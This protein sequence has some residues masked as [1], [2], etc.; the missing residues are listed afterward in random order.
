MSW[1]NL[2]MFSFGDKSVQEI[3]VQAINLFSASVCCI[4]CFLCLSECR[5]AGH[6]N[7]I[8]VEHHHLHIRQHPNCAF[9]PLGISAQTHICLSWDE[10][11]ECVRVWKSFTC[12]RLVF[13]IS[14]CA[15]TCWVYLCMK[16]QCVHVHTAARVT[17]WAKWSFWRFSLRATHVFPWAARSTPAKPGRELPGGWKCCLDRPGPTSCMHTY[18]CLGV[19]MFVLCN[20]NKNVR[21]QELNGNL[22]LCLFFFSVF[23]FSAF[24]L[25]DARKREGRKDTAE[26]ARKM[27]PGK[28]NPL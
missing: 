1:I 14:M 5:A 17:A 21:S 4:I 26:I 10:Q 27:A 28:K 20:A 24:I 9:P 6:L 22:N 25:A 8:R 7:F 19:C 16:S 2:F 3:I 18:K 11:A 23:C 13:V 15:C 12:I